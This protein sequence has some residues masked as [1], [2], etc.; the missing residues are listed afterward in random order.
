MPQLPVRETISFKIL[1]QLA[2]TGP[3]HI[4]P[5]GFW[6]PLNLGFGICKKQDRIGNGKGNIKE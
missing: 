5:T 2:M 3:F 6:L 4:R 1:S